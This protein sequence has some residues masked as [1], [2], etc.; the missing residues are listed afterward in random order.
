MTIPEDLPPRGW[1]VSCSAL[2]FLISAFCKLCSSQVQ[3]WGKHGFDFSQ[4]ELC[5]LR[6]GFLQKRIG[7]NGAL[8]N[9][10]CWNIIQFYLCCCFSGKDLLLMSL[11]PSDTAAVL[12]FN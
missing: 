3:P 11:V 9:V 5:G 1:W 12:L 4:E 6:L 7:K 10:E 8:T 2:F